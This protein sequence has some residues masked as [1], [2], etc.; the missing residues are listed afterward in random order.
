MYCPDANYSG[1]QVL[2]FWCSINNLQMHQGFKDLRT[3][4]AVEF[5]GV[6]PLDPQIFTSLHFSQYVLLLSEM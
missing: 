1:H 5:G 3:L 4:A 6:I 2:P